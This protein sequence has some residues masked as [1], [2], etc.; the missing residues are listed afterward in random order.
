MSAQVLILALYENKEI[1]PLAISNAMP[2]EKNCQSVG[3]SVY[4][5]FRSK[6]KVI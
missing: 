2:P 5:T 3:T 4:S 1:L 6:N